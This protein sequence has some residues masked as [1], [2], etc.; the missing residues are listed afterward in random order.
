MYLRGRAVAYI[1]FGIGCNENEMQLNWDDLRLF[2]TVAR[3]GGLRAASDPLGLS[4]PTLGRRMLAL[5]A[6][7][8]HQLFSRSLTGYTLTAA[9]RDL[10]AQAEEA[11]RAMLTITAWSEGSRADPLVRVSAGRWMSDLLAAN[12][13]SLWQVSDRIRLEFVT[14]FDPV[15]LGRRV[16]DIDLR[17]SRPDEAGLA[18]QLVGRVAHAVY[19]GR[20]RVNGV[21]DGYF[22][23]LSGEATGTPVALWLEAHHG[24]R[25]GVRGNDVHACLRLV[26]EGAG[27][28]VFPCFVG[29]ADPRLVRLGTPIPELTREL[30]L[31]THDDRRHDPPIRLVAGRLARLLKHS[32]PLLAGLAANN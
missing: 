8:G 28:S 6:A 9:G 13:D 16:A 7:I 3:S 10:L 27:L 25:I 19:S 29:D 15:D 11:E 1:Q 17:G 2:L 14:T 18:R 22:V 4:A 31:V 26:T 32:A 30:W 24:D 21:A 23:G 12:I 5:E 20:K